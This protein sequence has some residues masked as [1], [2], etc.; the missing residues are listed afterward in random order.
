MGA[1]ETY[2]YA[3]IPIQH[4][5]VGIDVVSL[6]DAAPLRIVKAIVDSGKGEI[7]LTIPRILRMR[8]ECK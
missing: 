1:A 3:I 7:G 8:K 5:V 2:P 6:D 4:K